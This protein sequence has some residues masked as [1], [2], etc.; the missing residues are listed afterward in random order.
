MGG[1]DEYR[2]Y[3]SMSKTMLK[4]L[5][6]DY[7]ALG[8]IHKPYYNA[9][10]NYRIVY[11]GSTISLGFDELGEH[12]VI[13]GNITKENVKLEFLKIDNKEYKEEN[14]EINA[15]ESVEELIE[16]INMLEIKANVFYKII[17]KRK[18]KI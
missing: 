18:K 14:I 8:H 6:F 11:P 1:N 16:T 10:E 3:N 4:Q 9:N 17:L 7:I 5:G 2:E 15:I 13:L 12:G